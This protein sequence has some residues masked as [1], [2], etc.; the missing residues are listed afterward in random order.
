M[1]RSQIV[2]PERELDNA[3]IMLSCLFGATK[4]FPWVV[5]VPAEETLN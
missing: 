1:S 2:L 4:S 5:S 3:D